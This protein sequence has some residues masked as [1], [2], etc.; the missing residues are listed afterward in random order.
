M[1]KLIDLSEE[2]ELA[3]SDEIKGEGKAQIFEIRDASTESAKVLVPQMGTDLVLIRE[4][5]I[6]Y[7]R[8]TNIQALDVYWLTWFSLKPKEK[9]GNFTKRFCEMF[10]NYSYSVNAQNKKL[11]VA[12]QQAI[13]GS[14]KKDEKQ[15]DNRSWMQKHVTQR[16]KEPD[17]LY[18]VS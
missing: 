7:R 17:D 14:D 18:D 4:G 13:S 8:F 12:M 16:G 9:G 3:I 15:K 6:D 5:K 1:S 2:V 11:V 10:S